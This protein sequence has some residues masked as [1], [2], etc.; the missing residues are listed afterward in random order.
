MRRECEINS[1]RQA[2]E[3]S[4]LEGMRKNLYAKEEALTKRE[5]D[6]NHKYS[7][8][9]DNLKE[10]K[11]DLDM[12]EISIAKKNPAAFAPRGS[13]LEPKELKEL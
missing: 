4:K 3:L 1:E 5:S 6:L 9:K 12:K 11:I 10:R 2:Q 7:L 13:V 8:K